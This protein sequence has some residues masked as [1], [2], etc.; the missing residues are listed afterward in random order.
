MKELLTAGWFVVAKSSPDQ[1]PI[2]PCWIGEVSRCHYNQNGEVVAVDVAWMKPFV[3]NEETLTT[4]S[5]LLFP[6][7]EEFVRENNGDLVPS[8]TSELK[9][10]AI[11]FAF[12]KLV[13]DQRIPEDALHLIS[14]DKGVAWSRQG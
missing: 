11:Y 7:H 8:I 1:D 4:A 2:A 14:E 6:F 5:Y 9:L 10:S 13:R 12:R 3:D